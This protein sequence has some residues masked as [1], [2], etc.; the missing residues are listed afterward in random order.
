MA[1]YVVADTPAWSPAQDGDVLM[2]D[3]AGMLNG[4]ATLTTQALEVVRPMSPSEIV[5]AALYTTSVDVLHDAKPRVMFQ[6][7]WSG[8]LHGAILP[9]TAVRRAGTKDFSYDPVDWGWV[10]PY[11]EHT[12][13][14]EAILAH[15]SKFPHKCP[16]CNGPA[17]IGLN[18]IECKQSC[19]PEYR[20]KSK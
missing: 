12:D 17:Y 7:R 3:P 20:S 14:E 18:Q 1:I 5:M 11:K 16:A 8:M 15:L 19:K 9:I 2:L 4:G 10:L 13:A 6:W